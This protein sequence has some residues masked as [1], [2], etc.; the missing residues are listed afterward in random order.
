[1]TPP[2]LEPINGNSETG[3]RLIAGAR[4]F[5]PHQGDQRISFNQQNL[6]EQRDSACMSQIP[7]DLISRTPRFER[8][9]WL[10]RFQKIR[11]RGALSVFPVKKVAENMR[12]AAATACGCGYA[13]L[14]PG[15]VGTLPA[16]AIFVLVA[17]T[18]AREFQIVWLAIAFLLSA[19]LTVTLGSWAER[20]WNTKDPRPFVLDEVA[21]F[22][23]TVLLFR[24]DSVALTALWAFLASRFFDIVKPPP[25]DRMEHLSAGWGILLDDLVASLYAAASLYLMAWLVPS[26]FGSS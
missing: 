16:V 23:L 20:R 19:V 10:D 9:T 6:R 4:T 21:G 15:T 2:V 13:P 12:L 3:K 17:E 18:Q 5:L 26:L 22:F 14:L 8:F 11:G 24:G 1:V 25:A 7:H